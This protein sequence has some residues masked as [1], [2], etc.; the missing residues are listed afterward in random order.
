MEIK[1]LWI[2]SAGKKLCIALAFIVTACTAHGS[3]ASD[4]IFSMAGNRDLSINICELL[5]CG[6]GRLVW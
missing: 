5:Y 1:A 4:H 2:Y 6:L 3:A